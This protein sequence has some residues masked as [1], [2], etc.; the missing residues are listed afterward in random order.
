ML[1]LDFLVEGRT[2]EPLPPTNLGWPGDRPTCLSNEGNDTRRIPPTCQENGIIVWGR[3]GES[4]PA[5][6]RLPA[7]RR[8]I[9]CLR[10]GGE[11]LA[12]LPS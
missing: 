3:P 11:S 5:V 8:R 4:L 7:S 6:N 9:A 12:C 1:L 2:H 10:A